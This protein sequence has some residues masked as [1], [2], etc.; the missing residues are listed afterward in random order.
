MKQEN[1]VSLKIKNFLKAL[2]FRPVVNERGMAMLIA[3]F[4][5]MLLTFIA[6]EVSYQTSV[7][8]TSASQEVNR[9]RA[10]YAAKA[11]VEISLLR[12]LIY[13]KAIASFG[14]KLGENKS[15]LD[16]IWN[17]PFAW[18]PV[19][20]DDLAAVEKDQIQKSV[21]E[22]TMKA[23]ILATIKS[24]G[25]KID[26]NDLGSPAKALADSTR[27][28][29]LKIFTNEIENNEDFADKHSDIN[30]EE[31]VNNI[32]D[33]IDE[34]EESLNGGDEKGYYQDELLHDK[35]PPNR[36][37]KTLEELH[38]VKDMKD[39]FYNLI[40]PKVT[41]YGSKGINVNYAPDEVLMAL[42]PQIDKEKAGLIIQRREDKE[43]GGFFKDQDEFLG[44][45]EGGEINIDTSEFNQDGIPLLFAEEQNFRVISTGNYSNATR[46]ITAITYDMDNLMERLITLLDEED[47]AKDQGGADGETDP[48]PPPN[49]GEGA[50]GNKTGGN[51]SGGK[52]SSDNKKIK[53]P[54]GRPTIVYWE[55]V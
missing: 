31:L 23:N 14:D 27:Q 26:I 40:A 36:S 12:I 42:D 30:F 33:W 18:P 45:L 21:K 11:G 53:I 9:I 49:S 54:K 52:S 15:M 51:E 48:N 55:E 46:E 22:S 50:D 3:I 38:M 32:A 34:D 44:F 1:Q 5:L 29:I 19:V 2:F 47:K 25:G 20:P 16:P 7:E 28:Q 8:Y 24:E 6:T 10:Q 4:S 43:K 17:F 39:E 35:I 13:K 41:I 37:L